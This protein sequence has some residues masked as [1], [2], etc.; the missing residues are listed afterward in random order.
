MCGYN[1][2]SC[3]ERWLFE[4]LKNTLLG[5]PARGF[6]LRASDGRLNWDANACYLCLHAGSVLSVALPFVSDSTLHCV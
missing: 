6:Y 4:D 3:L 2:N 5:T 1:V